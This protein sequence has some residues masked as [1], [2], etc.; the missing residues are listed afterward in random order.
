MRRFRLISIILA[1]CTVLAMPV[2]A[3]AAPPE[4]PLPQEP[5]LAGRVIGIDPGHQLTPD[6]RLESIAPYS[7]RTKMRMT[8]GASGI[9]T[10]VQEY[11]IALLISNKLK[12][13]LEDAGATVVMSRATH[14]V[15]LS[16]AER[17]QL[18]NNAAV[19]C[20]VRMHCDYSSDREKT[21]ISMLAPSEAANAA[22]Y[23][24]SLTLADDILTAVCSATGATR[25]AITLSTSQT[26]FYWSNTP[27]VTIETGFLSNSTEETLLMRDSYQAQLAQGMFNGLETYFNA[28]AEQ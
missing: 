17:A 26:A 20:W 6:T 1:V 10:G 8:A 2:A 14:D 7:Q 18:M 25:R 19:D 5:A 13:L 27:V 4:E 11:Q 9:K 21:G 16:N 15:S 24:N 23:P 22:I 12:A 3:F 28:K